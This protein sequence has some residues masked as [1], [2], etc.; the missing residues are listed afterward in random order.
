MN[1]PQ[2]PAPTDLPILDAIKE[3]WS[4][5]AFSDIPVEEEKIRIMF[6]ASR[7]A[8]SSYNEQP[9]RYIYATKNDGAEREKLESLLTEGNN[10]A[11]NAYI[12]IIDFAKKTLTRNGNPNGAAE[13][14]LG[15]SNA[16][17]VAQLPALGLVG[18]QMGGFRKEDA[19]AVLGVPDDYKSLSMIAV[20]YP[21][22][23]S[24]LSEDLQKRQAAARSRMDQSEFVFHG[25]WQG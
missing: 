8:P 15:A 25:H 5:V 24:T 21:A 12:L 19:N 10:W 17:L 1:Y 11:K 6:E 4:P 13:H 20:G 18:H 23:P 7:W 2:K 9:W 22:D 14:D 16:Y 3:R